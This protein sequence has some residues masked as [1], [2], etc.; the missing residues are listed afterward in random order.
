[1]EYN[2]KTSLK[3]KLGLYLALIMVFN[4]IVPFSQPMIV[5]A[6]TP[7]GNLTAAF[8]TMLSA[9][10][11]APAPVLASTV[12]PAPGAVMLRWHVGENGMY[13]MRFFD[14]EGRKNELTV[15]PLGA[16]NAMVNFD[17]YIGVNAAGEQVAGVTG[18]G[19]TVVGYMNVN[20]PLRAALPITQQLHVFH[21]MSGQ[22]MHVTQYFNNY[23]S[24]DTMDPLPG[25]GEPAYAGR[26]INN[27]HRFATPGSLDVSGN[28]IGNEISNHS[29][30]DFTRTYPTYPLNFND[31]PEYFNREVVPRVAGAAALEHFSRLSP[32]FNITL[33]DGFSFRFM[34]ITMHFLWQNNGE[35]YFFIDDPNL[36]GWQ[37][38]LQPGRVYSFD[39]EFHVANPFDFFRNDGPSHIVT[40]DPQGGVIT[41]V[42]RPAGVPPVVNRDRVYVFPG[43]STPP[44]ITANEIAHGVRSIPF[45]QNLCPTT[46]EMVYSTSAFYFSGGREPVL[47]GSYPDYDTSFVLMPGF[48]AD[49]TPVSPATPSVGLDIRFNLPGVFNESTGR[50][51]IPLN[52]YMGPGGMGDGRIPNLRANLVALEEGP[53]SAENF[54]V[55]IDLAN[56]PRHGGPGHSY[57]T[58]PDGV[59]P[60]FNAAG[61]ATLYTFAGNDRITLNDVS[62]LHRQI[63]DSPDRIRVQVGGLFPSTL[64]NPVT[65]TLDVP[66][67]ATPNFISRTAT[68]ATQE[69][70]F[71]TFLDYDVIDIDGRQH[72]RVVP[73]GFNTGAPRVGDYQLRAPGQPP[74]VDRATN[75]FDGS[76][77][78][79]L[80]PLPSIFGSQDFQIVFSNQVLAP[81]PPINIENRLLR[82]QWVQWTPD[83]TPNIG[84]PNDFRVVKNDPP[85]NPT[86]R[87]NPDHPPSE[88]DPQYNSIAE[89]T[90][91]T[92]WDLGRMI[93]IAALV[94]GS[95]NNLLVVEYILGRALAPDTNVEQADG[96]NLAIDP[97]YLDYA[98]IIIEIER[99][100][101]PNPPPGTSPSALFVRYTPTYIAH[102]TIAPHDPIPGRLLG[103]PTEWSPLPFRMSP[104]SGQN[105][106]YAR[107]QFVTD[108]T[109]IYRATPP[110]NVVRPGQIG[111]TFPN[112]YFMNVRVASWHRLRDGLVDGAGLDGQ[113]EVGLPASGFDYIVLDDLRSLQPPPPSGLNV[114]ADQRRDTPP[115][116]D[117]RYNIPLEALRSYVQT[118]YPS[119]AQSVQV[120]VDLFIGQFE[121]AIVDTFFSGPIPPADRTAADEPQRGYSLRPEHR[122]PPITQDLVYQHD[123]NGTINLTQREM[124]IMRGTGDSESGVL[125][126]TGIPLMWH[127]GNFEYPHRMPGMSI[128]SSPSATNAQRLESFAETYNLLSGN[129][130]SY[131]TNLI[132]YGLDENARYY[133]FAD[134][135]VHQFTV[136]TPAGVIGQRSPASVTSIFS[137]ISGDTTAGTVY[138]PGPEFVDPTAPTNVGVRDIEE[139]AATIFWDPLTPP[140]GEE[141]VTIEW[142]I[143]RIRDGQR[144][145]QEQML[146]R[147]VGVQSVLNSLEGLEPVGWS[148]TGD[149]LITFPGPTLV[150]NPND[151]ERYEYRQHIVELR[152]KT[153]SPNT[154]YFFYV[155]TVRIVDVFNEQLGEYIQTRSVSSW[156][157][158]PVTTTPVHPPI[159]L[160]QEDHSELHNFDAMT[161]VWVSWEHPSMT[162][163]LEAMGTEFY[164]QY[165]LR[166]DEGEWG[167]IL[168]VPVNQMV[169]ANLDPQNPNR[170]RYVVSGLEPNVLY[171]MRVRLFDVNG[172]DASLWSNV[173][174]FITDFDQEGADRDR[175]RDDWDNYLRRRLEELLRNPFWVIEDNAHT[176]RVVYRPGEM[177]AGL[178]L[179]HSGTTIPLHNTGAANVVYYFPASVIRDANQA[180]RGF[181]ATYTDTQMLF[182]PNFIN[183]DQNEIM[184]QMARAINLRGSDLTD[185]FLRVTINRSDLD[186]IQGV[187]TLTP[188]TALDME[189][190]ATNDSI[191]N[192][193]TWDRDMYHRLSAMVNDR[194]NDPVHR[195]NILQQIINNTSNEDML[196]NT[197]RLVE[198]IRQEII[199]EVERDMRVGGSGILSGEQLPITEFDSAVHVIATGTGYDTYVSAFRQG[200]DNQWLQHPTVEHHNGHAVIARGPST[201]VFAGRVVVIPGIQDVA[202]GSTI[203]NLVARYGLEDLFGVGVDLDQNATRQMIAGSIARM[204]GIPRTADPFAWMQANLNVQTTG[205][206]ATGFVSNQ[207]TIAMA[208]ALYEHRTNTRVDQM[209]IRNFQNTQGMQLDP[210]HAQ[211]VRA[212]FELG[213]ITNESLDPAGAITV[214]EFLNM[215]ALLSQRIRV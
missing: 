210:R 20:D 103:Q 67:T 50:Y 212:A 204:A 65:L 138:V 213:I 195:E 10:T 110:P 19:G 149:D 140:P 172:N 155:R 13:V 32:S 116:L 133:V 190:V 11:G 87:P 27:R 72:V 66:G 74:A 33:G 174:L 63:M 55:A 196:D 137:G 123:W 189:V 164:F 90:F 197:Y 111:F 40:T 109:H 176:M 60:Q 51:D 52:L 26:R 88:I 78:F 201:H 24:P 177:F 150:E 29:G 59:G 205:R 93:D 95:D 180:R 96:S 99:R 132:I 134:L 166:E 62:M 58:R 114:T 143:V 3:R 69:D 80:L 102:P 151:G 154:L 18:V 145:T 187:P 8:D 152:D 31:A 160:R 186:N 184:A 121:D 167:P 5:F 44:T 193:L 199:R 142:D 191:R 159:D 37:P 107:L 122:G 7:A 206:N 85:R 92:E 105:V 48:F 49:G 97:S 202:W 113:R 22:F 106:Y 25:D 214:G 179:Q 1:M 129:V 118:L 17:T 112:I 128:N 14:H 53:T 79:V 178:L 209:M 68:V 147:I 94:D 30:F 141:G 61:P 158:V 182:A 64:Y 100:D 34:G 70:P 131:P 200:A 165:Q 146:S 4:L 57:H 144:M 73:F 101:V 148:T 124:D 130:A 192:I 183:D 169:R 120:T 126:I 163:I 185:A 104:M 188:A 81:F 39:L 108:A 75:H 84:V 77:R 43:F 215:M 135:T 38:G 82:S 98:S 127:T 175:E 208:M 162:Q 83:G 198:A 207:E 173:L 86:M 6:D 41:H 12:N 45:A 156:V 139:T 15:T 181:S 170:I 136:T 91:W 36:P 194:L 76:T 157:E 23:F 54:T 115:R 21:P 89:L 117:V 211:A 16:G 119:Q 71:Y 42:P 171:N 2:L 46:G 168:T 28:P 125:R 47:Q 161:Q 56:V 35:F 153:L 203:T 9:Q